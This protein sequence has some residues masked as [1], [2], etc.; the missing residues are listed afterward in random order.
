[1]RHF[2]EVQ[3]SN[4]VSVTKEE[5]V[6]KKKTNKYLLHKFGT[7]ALSLHLQSFDSV[8]VFFGN[9]QKLESMKSGCHSPDDFAIA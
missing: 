6:E 7:V 3:Y 9:G 4:D 8:W 5:E 1:M 2:T